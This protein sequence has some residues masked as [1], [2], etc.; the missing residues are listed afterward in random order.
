MPS[1]LCQ[2]CTFPGRSRFPGTKD[3]P[4]K[5]SCKPRRSPNTYYNPERQQDLRNRICR[6]NLDQYSASLLPHMPPLFHLPHFPSYPALSSIRGM[7]NI[8][9]ILDWFLAEAE[10]SLSRKV[11]A[12][13]RHAFRD[14]RALF[15]ELHPFHSI[16]TNPDTEQTQFTQKDERNLPKAAI[17][18]NET[19]PLG[20]TTALSP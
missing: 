19:A 3:S 16:S 15:Q 12:E 2:R 1:F 4:H 13:L 20:L 14:I 6:R 18:S 10:P 11:P 7:G 9:Q 17:H 8:T 5:H